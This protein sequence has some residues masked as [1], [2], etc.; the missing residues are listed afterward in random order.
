WSAR[1]AWGSS[2][3]V[4]DAY[5]ASPSMRSSSRTLAGWSS[6]TRILAAR[7]AE[8]S[9][10]D[11]RGFERGVEGLQELRDLDRLREV[12]KESGHEAFC[13]VAWH[14]IGTE[15]DD[16]NVSGR[17]IVVQDL[18]R[19]DSADAGQVD[20]HQD[21]VRLV[22]P[23]QLNPLIPVHGAQQPQRRAARDQL[24]DQLQIGRVVLDVE[25]RA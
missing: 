2:V 18:H 25:E 3:D 17:R 8:A 13:D 23:C 22:G 20:V 21:H 9:R 24:L 11:V 14:R 6:T 5:P 1:T 12:G 7:R 10:I 19:L 16:G 4:T 15:G